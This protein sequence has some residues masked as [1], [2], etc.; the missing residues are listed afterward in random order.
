MTSRIYL[1]PPNVGALEREYLLSAFDSGW[2]APTGPDVDAF[3]RELARAAGTAEAVALSSGTAALHLALLLAGV[4]PG[5][6]VL[7]QSL[8]FAATANA[9]HYTGARPV[10]VDSCPTTWTIDPDLVADRLATAA[11]R[12][13]LPAAVIPVDVFGQCAD[14]DALNAVCARYGVPVIEDAAEALGATYRG[15]PAGGLAEL[16]ILSFNGNKIITTGGGGAL[17]TDSAER[18]ARAR[19]LATQAREPAVHYEHREIGYNYRLSNLSAALGR[20]QLARLP[21]LVR[22]RQEIRAAYTTFLSG[23]PGIELMP[24]APY[25]AS[26]GWLTVVQVDPARCGLT[27]AELVSALAAADIE[28]RPV[29]KP[30]H[31]Q[32]AY[33]GCEVL[34]TGC[35]TRL[36]ERGL[37]LPSGSGMSDAD[38]ERVIDV[39]ARAL[40]RSS[41]PIPVR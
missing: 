36:F 17:L 3:E 28:A 38:V 7:V 12:G 23:V 31:L 11:R 4:R 5:G 1:S 16:G 37:C 25:G 32:P 8:T 2:V 21:E 41:R 30:M 6:T 10:F 33:A 24:E 29:W 27:A 40:S 14:Y 18:A 13:D 20:A 22:R 15:R 34:D 26:N 39:L 35:A 19:H 9:V